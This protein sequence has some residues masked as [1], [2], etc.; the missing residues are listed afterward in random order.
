VLALQAMAFRIRPEVLRIAAEV[1]ARH[2]VGMLTN[3]APLLREA[4][5]RH[6]PELARIFEPILYSFQFGHIK[7][8]RALFE[9]VARA[10]ALEPGEICLIDDQRRNVAAAREAGWDALQF[11]SAAQL[12]GALVERGLLGDAA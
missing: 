12:R 4:V 2:R 11:E 8:E 10:L 5:P 3:N 1:A 9:A 7:P 6:F